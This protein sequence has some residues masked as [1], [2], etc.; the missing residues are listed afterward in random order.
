MRFV[1]NVVRVLALAPLAAGCAQPASATPQGSVI[2]RPRSEQVA[3][4]NQSLSLGFAGVPA[5]MPRVAGTSSPNALTPELRETI[6]AQDSNPLENPTAAI[7][8]YGFDGNGPFVP[9][10]GDVQSATHNV[11]ATKSEPDKNTY[12][13]LAGQRGADSNYDYGTHFLFQGHEL[14]AGYITRVNLDAD[15]AHRVTLL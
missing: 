13:V 5:A 8:A 11:E 2:E 12:L 10:Y 1:K 7:A 15:F 9:A 14:G 4:S 3:V 6:A